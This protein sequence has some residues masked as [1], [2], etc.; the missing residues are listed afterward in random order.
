MQTKLTLRL[1]SALI[2]QAKQYAQ[3]REISLSQL[4]TEYFTVLTL[5]SEDKAAFEDSLPPI[6]RSLAGLLKE[7]NYDVEEYR[8]YLEEKNA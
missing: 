2:E 6:T 8:R 1:D 5:Y 7:S 3:E 4:V